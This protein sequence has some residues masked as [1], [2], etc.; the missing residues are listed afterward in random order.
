MTLYRFEDENGESFP[1][2]WDQQINVIWNTKRQRIIPTYVGSTKRA[3]PDSSTA[4]NHSHVCGINGYQK[5]TSYNQGE[6]FPRMW[7][8]RALL[9]TNQMILRI[10]PTYV[11]S[12][13]HCRELNLIPANHS[14][15]CGINSAIN[16]GIFAKFESFPRMWDQ[17]TKEVVDEDATRIIPTYVGSTFS[18]AWRKTMRTNHSHVCGINLVSDSAAVSRSE[19]FPRMWDQLNNPFFNF[20]RPRIIPTYVG[21]TFRRHRKRRSIPN[22]S[23]VCGINPTN[24]FYLASGNTASCSFV[25]LEN[26]L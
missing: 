16:S 26:C 23:H 17:P 22:H 25:L 5:I 12:T 24:S 1:R 13:C 8:Q 3:L 7:D 18:K 15:V 4:A 19:S 2:M 14:H 20:T 9:K 21:S 6:S 10:I 11:G